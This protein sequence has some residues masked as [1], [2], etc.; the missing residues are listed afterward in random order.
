MTKITCLP[1]N[2]LPNENCLEEPQGTGFKR[3]TI[4]FMKE[5]KEFKEDVNKH[6]IEHQEANNRYLSN[7]QVKY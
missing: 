3:R 5:D 7:G 2:H 4:N 6:F 1:P